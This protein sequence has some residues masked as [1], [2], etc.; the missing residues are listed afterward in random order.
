MHLNILFFRQKQKILYL[1]TDE[2][3]NDWQSVLLPDAAKACAIGPAW[4]G[5]HADPVLPGEPERSAHGLRVAR[6]PATRDAGGAHQRKQRR[7]VPHAFA[8]VCVQVDRAHE[9]T[10]PPHP[11][12]CNAPIL[13]P[14]T[15]G[16]LDRHHPDATLAWRVVAVRT[17]WE[18]LTMADLP[19]TAVLRRIPV[20]AELRDVDLQALVAVLRP[21]RLPVGGQLFDQG[22]PGGT[23]HL[24]AR[25]ELSVRWQDG[26]SNQEIEVARIGP[27]EFVG[28]MALLD[29]GPRS[30]GVVARRESLLYELAVE[31]LMLLEDSSPAA[32]SAVLAA[33]TTLLGDRIRHVNRQMEAILEGHEATLAEP[34]NATDSGVFGRLWARLSTR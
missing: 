3:L 22:D 8:H 15:P 23:M 11:P 19:L 6:V 20:F 12:A 32:A 14:R 31:D 9:H 30:A 1:Q 2:R 18:T 16:G 34:D 10:V 29:L 28:E 21:C 13:P 5:A 24:L 7:V 33:V 25:G 27:G 4:M 17:L 26:V